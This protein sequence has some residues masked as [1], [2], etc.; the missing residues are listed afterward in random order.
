MASVRA[1]IGEYLRTE[2]G[3]RRSG[4]ITFGTLFGLFIL[5]FVGEFGGVGWWLFLVALAYGA[6]WV[7]AYFMWQA[8]KGDI[9]RI[10]SQIEAARRAQSVSNGTHST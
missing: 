9:E 6:G 7:W 2:R 3:F 1:R 10:K 5:W 8:M 4:T